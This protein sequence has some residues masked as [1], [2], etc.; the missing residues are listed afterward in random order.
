MNSKSP[1][2]ALALVLLGSC[3]Q[4]PSPAAAAQESGQTARPEVAKAEALPDVRAYT[5]I[6][7]QSCATWVAHEHK[8]TTRTPQTDALDT[9]EQH[10]WLAGYVTGVGQVLAAPDYVQRPRTLRRTDA[11]GLSSWVTDYCRTHPTE[12]V[13]DAA[14]ELVHH[15]LVEEGTR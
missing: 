9:I 2:I 12:L 6:P 14:G 1:L 7:L 10:F 5:G 13:S 11:E 8:L 4:K 3:S 15:L